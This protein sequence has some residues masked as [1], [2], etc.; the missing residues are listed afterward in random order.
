MTTG[1]Q[2]LKWSFRLIFKREKECCNG[3]IAIKKEKCGI[4]LKKAIHI[5]FN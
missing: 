3:T 1:K 5:R 2:S 4:N